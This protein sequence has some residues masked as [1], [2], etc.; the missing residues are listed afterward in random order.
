MHGHFTLLVMALC[1][2][3]RLWQAKSAAA[4]TQQTQ[5]SLSS[6]LLGGEGT[7]RWLLPR[8]RGK[9]R[10]GHLDDFS[11]TL[12]SIVKRETTT[13]RTVPLFPKGLIL[14]TDPSVPRSARG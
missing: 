7:A 4:P 14:E 2:A 6:A 11:C 1:T 12:P 10:Q 13:D 8:K 5:S 9:P 3:F